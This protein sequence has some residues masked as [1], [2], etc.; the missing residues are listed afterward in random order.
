MLNTQLPSNAKINGYPMEG[1]GVPMPAPESNAHHA[2][3]HATA[4]R[5][6]PFQY[7]LTEEIASVIF[8]NLGKDAKEEPSFT[9]KIDHDK[10]SYDETQDDH[11]T[12]FIYTFKTGML[13]QHKRDVTALKMP[14]FSRRVTHI[15]NQIKA[16]NMTMYLEKRSES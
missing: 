14:A 11:T 10:I 6:N 3:T 9:M 2:Q 12:S 1:F 4:S 15:L 7:L 8:T 13:M 16:K 5:E